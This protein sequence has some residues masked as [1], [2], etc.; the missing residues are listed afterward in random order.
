MNA[1]SQ[2]PFDKNTGASRETIAA[3][4]LSNKDLVKQ[5]F[6]AQ[7]EHEVED[8]SLYGSSDFFASL[9]RRMDARLAAGSLDGDAHA[10]L[11]SIY[12]EALRDYGRQL[13]RLDDHRRR[14]HAL[15]IVGVETSHP[16]N[17]DPDPASQPSLAQVDEQIARLRAAGLSHSRIAPILGMTAA[18]VRQRWSRCVRSVFS[19]P[20]RRAS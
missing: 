15:A 9:L 1:V 7:L 3:F 11:Q 14:S 13:N 19:H 4:L 20:S 16:G 6:R 8:G 17:A 5:R 12:L 10:V 18:A 2:L